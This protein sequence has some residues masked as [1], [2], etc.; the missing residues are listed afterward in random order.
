MPIWRAFLA[1]YLFYWAADDGMMRDMEQMEQIAMT[2]KAGAPESLYEVW[3]G[4]GTFVVSDGVR[5]AKREYV[6]KAR[7]WVSLKSGYV[8][9]DVSGGVEIVRTDPRIQ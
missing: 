7:M 9:R 3:T 5:I 1:L 6:G 4:A 8:V 2:T